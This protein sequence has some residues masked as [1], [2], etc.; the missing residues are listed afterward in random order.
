MMPINFSDNAILN[1]RSF[2]YRCTISEVSKSE[3]MSLLNKVNP[4]EKRGTV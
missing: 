3:T 2:A 1:I 4:N